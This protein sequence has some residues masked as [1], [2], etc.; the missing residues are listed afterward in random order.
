MYLIAAIVIVGLII[1]FVT[2]FN[3]SKKEELTK[4]YELKEE[5]RIESSKVLDY[6]EA[7]GDDKLENFTKIFA[8]YAGS[9]FKI[10]YI[11]GEAGSLEGYKYNEGVEEPVDVDETSE[12]GK[13]IIVVNETDYKFDVEEGQNFYFVISQYNEGE[14]YVE[15]N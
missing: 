15:T 6:I 8:E 4:A 14:Q 2:V 9:E 13:V 1:G 10:Y 12:L 7:S 11:T 5:L 3:F